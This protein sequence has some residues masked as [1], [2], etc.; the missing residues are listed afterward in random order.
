MLQTARL[1]LLIVMV[2]SA[3]VAPVEHQAPLVGPAV[4]WA[5]VIHGGAGNAPRDMDSDKRRAIEQALVRLRDEGAAQLQDGGEAIDVIE[6]I[7]AALEDDPLFN[8]GR[9]AV[10]THQRTHELDAAIMDGRGHRCGAVAGLRTVKNPIRLARLVMERSPHVFLIAD[11]AESFA[12]EQG[13]ELV[14]G[15][16]FTT[17]ARVE[18]LEKVLAREAAGERHGT[19]GAVARDRV[20][21]LAA[22]TSTGGLTNKRF[23][24][25]GDVPVIGAGTWADNATCAVSASGAGEEFIRHG[26]AQAVSALMA[27]GGLDLH[28]AAQQVIHEVLAPGDGGVIAVDN[29]G[30]IEMTFSTS[31]FYRAAADANG[32]REVGIWHE[33]ATDSE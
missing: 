18:S 30:H 28:S 23:G 33:L 12:A 9:G 10:L 8:A 16:Y 13:L 15:S 24:R 4:E 7:V 32:R 26:A 2:T 29:L 31:S 19:V 22:A 21:N 6:K 1:I 20:G 3:C 27:Y 5:L 17:P 14:E 25:I 11:G